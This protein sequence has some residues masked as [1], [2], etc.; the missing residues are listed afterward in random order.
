MQWPRTDPET[1]FEAL[2]QALPAETG[3]MA[4]AC[5]AFVRAKQVQP[6]AHLWRVV[7]CSCG[8]DQPLR[9]VAGPGTALEESMTD[10]AGAE[11]LRACGPWGQAMRRRMLPMAASAP[12]PAGRRVVVIDASRLHAP[13]A[14]GTE[15]RRPLA[16]DWVSLQGL[17]GWGSAV[18]PGDT[19][20]HCP[21]AAG[22]VVVAARGAAPC[23]G[24]QAAVQQG[25][26][27][28][29]RRHPCRGGRGDAAGAP[30]ALRPAW[31]RQHT[32][33]LRTLVVTRRAAGGPHEV[34]GG[35]PAERVHAEP[36]HRARHPCRQGHTTGTPSAESLVWAG[37]GWVLPPLAP[38][39]RS[40]QPIL[41]LSRGR[42][43][44]ESAIKRWQRGRDVDAWRAQ[45]HSPLAA[46]W[47][48][49]Q[50][51]YALM[52][53]RRMRRPLGDTWSRLE[54]ER[55]ATWW[56]VWGR[57]KETIA[58]LITGAL[59]WKADAGEAC[60]KVWAA[61]PRRRP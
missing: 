54:P 36:A 51:L 55:V 31:T 17:E 48:H 14:T 27:R 39:V 19:R 20:R 3:P 50:G 18:H 42:W 32:A 35:R 28:L 5:H 1:L 22:A 2:V 58:P 30:W 34:R 24:M 15:H 10:Q 41:A 37:W 25:A 4:R 47:L 40:A 23:Q 44:V 13:G 57:R 12:R 8:W 53:A 43:H 33:P 60:L 21:L 56:R 16:L 61:R 6:P 46:V 45:A 59:G 9:E 38:A 49:G 7:C 26:A 11:R 29:V 52:L